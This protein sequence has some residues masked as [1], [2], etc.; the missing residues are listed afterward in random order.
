MKTT[1]KSI[2]NWEKT[3]KG[4]NV[5]MVCRFDKE[6]G[7]REL[8]AGFNSPFEALIEMSYSIRAGFDVLLI[9]AA[10]QQYMH[11]A[12][13]SGAKYRRVTLEEMKPYAISFSTFDGHLV[14]CDAV[15]K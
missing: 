11:H 7:R 9:G 15:S 6:T 12:E 5:V 13:M 14:E 4:Y 1:L 3:Y 2:Q 8:A 10:G